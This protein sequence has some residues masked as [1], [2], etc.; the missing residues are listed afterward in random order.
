METDSHIKNPEEGQETEQE[1]QQAIWSEISQECCQP[2]IKK[3]DPA[4]SPSSIPQA[5]FEIPQIRENLQNAGINP[6]KTR[7]SI[8]VYEPQY[9]A[10]DN[11]HK[12]HDSV[13]SGVI[14][15]K[16][17]GLCRGAKVDMVSPQAKYFDLNDYKDREN[18]LKDYITD[19]STTAVTGMTSDLKKYCLDANNP[20]LK[21]FNISQG[22]SN[23]SLYQDILQEFEK[24]PESLQGI[25]G[26]LIGEDKAQKWV[27]DVIQ[28]RQKKEA[29][30]QEHNLPLDRLITSGLSRSSAET[31]DLMQAIINQVDQTL[32]YNAKFNQALHDYQQTTEAIANKGITVVVA[33]SNDGNFAQTKNHKY[34]IKPG[35]EYNWYAMSNHIISVG[36]ADIHN[37]PSIRLD[38]TIAGFSSKGNDQYHPTIVA[39]GANFPSD[40]GSLISQ[41]GAS[42]TSFATPQVATTVA[43]MLEQNPNLSFNEIKHLLT[44]N[45]TLLANFG[46]EAQGAGFLEIDKAI[47]AARDSAQIKTD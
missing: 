10:T 4:F 39:Q 23:V 43:L 16:Q 32:E 40:R 31:P 41:N 44:T 7:F 47:I 33:A 25:I 19:W 30:L 45:A 13:V 37:T 12:D 27:D 14:N 42:G 21:V 9:Q 15:D 38:D 29:F 35:S 11:A 46:I 24:N 6:D 5:T 36:A 26:D 2:P 18:P 20:D 17:Y 22:A 34:E 3:D 1:A 28:A 8:A